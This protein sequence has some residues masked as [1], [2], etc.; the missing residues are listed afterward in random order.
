MSHAAA[1]YGDHDRIH[2]PFLDPSLRSLIAKPNPAARGTTL[3]H[4]YADSSFQS[5]P[6]PFKSSHN[7]LPEAPESLSGSSTASYSH[8]ESLR[9]HDNRKAS[10]ASFALAA[11][12]ERGAMDSRIAQKVGEHSEKYPRS[13]TDASSSPQNSPR[14]VDATVF[15]YT[16]DDDNMPEQKDHVAWVLVSSQ[17]WLS[18]I[19]HVFILANCSVRSVYHVLLHSTQCLWRYTPF[20]YFCSSYSSHLFECFGQTP[21]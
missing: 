13:P 8:P 7:S 15:T 17:Y 18:S 12:A 4:V 10:P 3:R 9:E 1:Y 5:R 19:H 21:P 2:S 6:H 14:P 11:E 16:R 20:W